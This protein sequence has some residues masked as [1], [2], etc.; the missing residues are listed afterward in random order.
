MDDFNIE[1]PYQTVLDG[2]WTLDKLIAM[3]KD[4]YIDVNGSSTEDSGDI[5][6]F[7]ILPNCYGCSI[8]MEIQTW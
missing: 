2:S 6:G 4:V 8:R 7:S 1:Y 5:H 3:T